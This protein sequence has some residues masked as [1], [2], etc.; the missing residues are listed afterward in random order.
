MQHISCR[1]YLTLPCGTGRFGRNCVERTDGTVEQFQRCDQTE[2]QPGD[3]FVIE[4]PGG[5]GFGAG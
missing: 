3:V 5:G 4:M 2:M 1:F